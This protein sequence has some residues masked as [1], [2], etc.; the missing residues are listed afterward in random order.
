M[1]VDPRKLTY[2][3]FMEINKK[4]NELTHYRYGLIGSLRYIPLCMEVGWLSL[5]ESNDK[6][7]ASFIKFSL[8]FLISRLSIL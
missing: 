6:D 1:V 4:E 8:L 3:K 5:V 7:I 2:G